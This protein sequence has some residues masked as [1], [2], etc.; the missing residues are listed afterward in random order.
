VKDLR[1]NYI[2]GE[3][4]EGNVPSNPFEL[5]TQWF[6]DSSNAED[7]VEP[8]AM[9]LTTVNIDAEPDSR[10]VL[11]KDLRKEAFVFYTNYESHKGQ[12]IAQNGNCTL[13]FPWV[14]LERQVIVRGFAS[15]VSEQES[16][17]YFN[18][19][20]QSSRIGAWASSQSA[21]IQSREDLEQQL[22]DFETKYTDTAIPKP[23][24]WGGFAVEPKEIEF[25][26]GR[27]NRLHDRLV[28]RKT[29][30]SWNVVRL[31]P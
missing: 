16:I 20:P 22:K 29:D 21:P 7:I 18:S 3:L 4:I 23:P 13:L 26:Q 5:F 14:N 19:R 9:V 28:Y 2:S 6:E 24:H 25:W 11:L 15:K 30:G 8:N 12:Q 27:P 17:A 1:K 31:Q 10:I